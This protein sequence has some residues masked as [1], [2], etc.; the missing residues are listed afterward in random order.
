MLTAYLPDI[1]RG[2][3]RSYSQLADRAA[4][5]LFFAAT[6]F[7]AG[8]WF[9]IGLKVGALVVVLGAIHFALGGQ[10]AL[11]DKKPLGP[12]IMWGIVFVVVGLVIVSVMMKS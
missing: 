2:F 3:E 6:W 5:Y 12:T 7:A 11:G 10:T 8:S 9:D 4:D 1:L